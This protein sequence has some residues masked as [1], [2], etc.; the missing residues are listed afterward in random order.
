MGTA[1]RKSNNEAGHVRLSQEKD[2]LATGIEDNTI[3][4]LLLAN[5]QIT[6]LAIKNNI[7]A[8]KVRVKIRTI[9]KYLSRIHLRS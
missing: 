7:K 3:C 9:S 4:D 6:V 5:S 2:R 1:L 8:P